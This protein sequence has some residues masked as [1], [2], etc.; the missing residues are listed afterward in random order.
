MQWLRGFFCPHSYAFGSV[1]KEK[2]QI[3]P[4]ADLKY[5][6]HLQSFEE[7]SWLKVLPMLKSH[8]TLE[9]TVWGC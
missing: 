3:P 8:P 9:V 6:I 1:G 5:E 7:V 4:N 2:F